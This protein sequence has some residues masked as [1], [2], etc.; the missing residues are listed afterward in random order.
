MSTTAEHLAELQQSLNKARLALGELWVMAS[1]VS[2]IDTAVFLLNEQL[3][4][5]QRSLEDALEREL[6]TPEPVTELERITR[7]GGRADG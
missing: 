1:S 6:R 3:V 7:N 2:G 5:A 4:D